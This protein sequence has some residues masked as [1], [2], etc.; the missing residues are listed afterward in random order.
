M[1]VV[2]VDEVVVVVVVVVVVKRIVKEILNFSILE[3]LKY[4]QMARFQDS[5]ISRIRKKDFS[6]VQ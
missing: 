3:L 5:M 1:V 2:I 6:R 4:C